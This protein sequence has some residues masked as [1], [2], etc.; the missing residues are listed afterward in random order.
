MINAEGKP[1]GKAENRVRD[2]E[3][4]YNYEE[5]LEFTFKDDDN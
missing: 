5:E 4:S 3:K 2:H 1:Y